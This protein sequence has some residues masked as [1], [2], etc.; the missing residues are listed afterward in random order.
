[1]PEAFLDLA[2][3]AQLTNGEARCTAL[4]LCDDAG[5]PRRVFEQGETASFLYE[6]EL[7]ADVEVPTVGVELVSD[8]GIIVHGKST[9]EHGSAVPRNVSRGRR[10][11]VRQDIALELAIGEYTFNLGLGALSGHDYDGARAPR[12]PSSM[13]A[14]P[15][16]AGRLWRER[17][18]SPCVLSALRSSPCTTVSPIFPEAAGYPWRGRRHRAIPSRARRGTLGAPVRGRR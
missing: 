7:L 4:A 17:S 13:P 16:S 18:P 14:W 1:M 3:V 2:G 11:R 8:K 9:I 15:A 10:L 5:R 6:F 12:T